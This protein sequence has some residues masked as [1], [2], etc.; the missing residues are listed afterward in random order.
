M[1]DAKGL[2]DRFLGQGP[3]AAGGQQP[4]EAPVSG[5]GGLGGLSGAADKLNLQG[6]LQGKGGLL[7]GAAAG[8]LAG[9]L[10]GGKKPKKIAGTALKVGGVALVGGLAYKAWRDW[11]ANKA[12][13][14]GGASQVPGATTGAGSVPSLPS[15][16]GTPF[17]PSAAA[18]QEDLSLGL[19]RAMIS[20]AKADGH[21]D[22]TERER[23]IAQLDAIQI[24]ES[25]RA[26][27]EAEVKKPLNIDEV[28]SAAKSPEQAAEIYAASLLAID[29]EGA[30]EKGYL[31]MLAARLQ[32]D[33][34]LVAHLHANAAELETA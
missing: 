30:A 21:I 15:P 3:T 11:Q 27:V 20:A 6:M 4:G 19:I 9:L 34:D 12:P 1:Y 10:L 33:P 32:L 29:T 13:Q 28:A 22:D 18:E 16:E 14:P 24:D 5:L 25:Q 23:I 8:G 7:T 26:F 2:L 17:L 31:A